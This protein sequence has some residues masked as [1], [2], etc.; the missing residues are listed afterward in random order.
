MKP[1]M[2]EMRN[3]LQIGWIVVPFVLVLMMDVVTWR[4]RAVML[5]VDGAM[6]VSLTVS[7]GFVRA[8]PQRAVV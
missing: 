6:F 1:D 8:T 4:N 5:F 7:E 2:M 3:R